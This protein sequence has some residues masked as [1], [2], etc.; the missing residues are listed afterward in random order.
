LWSRGLRHRDPAGQREDAEAEQDQAVAAGAGGGQSSV[1][2][3]PL[4]DMSHFA[5]EIYEYC[6]ALTGAF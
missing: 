2:L 4:P 1:G 3:Q 6:A 5:A